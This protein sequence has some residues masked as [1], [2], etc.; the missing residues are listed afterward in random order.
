VGWQAIAR[1]GRW[2]RS[3][4]AEVARLVPH[5]RGPPNGCWGSG[6]DGLH[7]AQ[8]CQTEI[9]ALDEERVRAIARAESR[10]VF[11]AMIGILARAL[12]G[13]PDHYSSRACC[14]PPGVPETRWK[15]IAREIG[16][17]PYPGA[18]WHIVTR[19]QYEMWLAGQTAPSTANDVPEW[20]IEDSIL[21][22]RATR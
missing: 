4:I 12:N 10:D 6:R 13:E 22:Y 17:L 1:A 18:R 11:R 20:T 8:R 16:R 14:G 15:L 5:E 9:V 21:G 3:L 2:P 7:T 19:A